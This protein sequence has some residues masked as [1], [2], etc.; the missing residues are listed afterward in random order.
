[1]IAFFKGYRA[2]TYNSIAY[3]FKNSNAFTAK[4]LLQRRV[5]KKGCLP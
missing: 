5:F 1:M 4:Y 3:F 2:Q